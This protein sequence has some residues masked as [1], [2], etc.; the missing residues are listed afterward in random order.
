MNSGQDVPESKDGLRAAFK[1]EVMMTRQVT[2]GVAIGI[3]IGVLAASHFGKTESVYAQL[4]GVAAGKTDTTVVVNVAGVSGDHF[5]VVV[6]T[7]QQVMG[8]YRV[9]TATGKI[10]LQSIRNY[11]WDF[12][13]EEFNGAE[14][15]P[16]E[17]RAIVEKR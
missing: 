10:T 1:E 6:D 13:M 2:F 16:H 12:Q 11:R 9:D 5:V 3:V 17:V 8:S 15:R 4:P 14:P 7:T